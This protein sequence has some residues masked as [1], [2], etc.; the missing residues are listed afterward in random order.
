M[1]TPKKIIIQDL[2]LADKE[3]ARLRK[4]NKNLKLIIEDSEKQMKLYMEDRD[5]L[6]KENKELKDKLDKLRTD[7]IYEE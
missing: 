7:N 4:E 6:R 3:I 5:N 1:V 2:E